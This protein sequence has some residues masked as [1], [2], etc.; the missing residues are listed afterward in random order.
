MSRSTYERRP[1]YDEEQ[2]FEAGVPLKEDPD[3]YKIL[4]AG[5]F[6]AGVK[7]PSFVATVIPDA[8]TEKLLRLGENRSW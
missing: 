6:T 3:K 1:G 2:R 8:Q 5:E 4:E 7:D